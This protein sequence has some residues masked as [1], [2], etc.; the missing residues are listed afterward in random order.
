LCPQL[1]LVTFDNTVL[2]IT[3]SFRDGGLCAAP[4][5]RIIGRGAQL[6]IFARALVSQAEMLILDEPTSA[7]D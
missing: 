3:G 2:D 4:I 5:R 7:L 6:I 1:F